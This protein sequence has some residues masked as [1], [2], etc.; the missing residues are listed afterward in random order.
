MIKIIYFLGNLILIFQ[1][2]FSAPVKR[3]T[4]RVGQS[5]PNSAIPVLLAARRQIAKNRKCC[6]VSQNFGDWKRKSLGSLLRALSNQPEG[7]SGLKGCVLV[8]KVASVKLACICYLI[9]LVR[10]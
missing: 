6:F 1:K 5:C 10:I 8:I 3:D 4:E 7:I 2:T 9:G